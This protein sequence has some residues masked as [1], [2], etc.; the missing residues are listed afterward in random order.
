MLEKTMNVSEKWKDPKIGLMFFG[1]LILGIIVVVALTRERIVSPIDNQ[2]TVTG[3]GKVAYQPDIA[4]VT[5]GVQVEKADSAE[6]ALKQLNEK[7]NNI[8]AAIEGASVPKKNIQT[9]A[10]SLYPQYDFKNGASVVSG[11][12][13][14]QQ[15][16]I[17]IEGIQENTELVSGVI[18]AAS[19]AGINQVTGISFDVSSVSDLK[20]QARIMAVADAKAKA[21]ELSNVT[22]T[23][24][25][26]IVGWYENAVGSPDPQ[27]LM[28]LGGSAMDAKEVSPRIPS[29]TQEIVVEMSLNY[30]VK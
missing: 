3:Q 24:L 19:S 30:Q 5:L 23:R 15:L 7:M 14:N 9:Q 27:P 10:Y 13:A 8:V 2:V 4:N 17:K 16:S 6:N 25:G 21:L 18:T 22:G 1:I 28:G 20:Q 29:G 11:Y 12:G 26:K